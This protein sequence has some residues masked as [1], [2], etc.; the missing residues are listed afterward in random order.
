MFDHVYAD[1]TPDLDAQRESFA[2]MRDRLGDEEF[3]SH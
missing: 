3:R 2:A 1:R